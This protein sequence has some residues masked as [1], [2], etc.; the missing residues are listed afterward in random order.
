MVSIAIAAVLDALTL[1]IDCA[2]N[3]Q[4]RKSKR[5]GFEVKRDMNALIAASDMESIPQSFARSSA[6]KNARNAI[7]CGLSVSFAAVRLSDTS[8]DIVVEM[9]VV[10]WFVL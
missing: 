8:E 2:E 7:S 4:A 10:L 3:A 1:I 9:H 5:R 6:G